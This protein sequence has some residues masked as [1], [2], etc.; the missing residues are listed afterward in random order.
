MVSMNGHKPLGDAGGHYE[1]DSPPI[2]LEVEEQIPQGYQEHVAF[3]EERGY[4]PSTTDAQYRAA[5]SLRPFQFLVPEEFG[6]DIGDRLVVWSEG[7]VYVI[8]VDGHTDI[9]K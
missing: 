4:P 8:D 3:M 2:E 9:I 5:E 1:A 6:F 7:H